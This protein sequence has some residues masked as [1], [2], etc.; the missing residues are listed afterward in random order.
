[1]SQVFGVGSVTGPLTQYAPFG[2][3]IE[4]GTKNSFNNTLTKLEKI[5]RKFLENETVRVRDNLAL[6]LDV[7]KK[8]NF[9]LVYG[10]INAREIN[11]ITLKDFSPVDT[12]QEKFIALL[13][14]KHQHLTGYKMRSLDSR[15]VLDILTGQ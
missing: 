12:G 2:I 6:P 5:I 14:G 3:E 1:M 7:I 10:K 13:F 9:Y 11:G 15:E 4:C 8:K